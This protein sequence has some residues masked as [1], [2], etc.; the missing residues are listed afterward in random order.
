MRNGMAMKAASCDHPSH[1]AVGRNT[2]SDQTLVLSNLSIPHLTVRKIH[3]SDLSDSLSKGMADFNARPTH[4]VFLCA[5]YPIV[6]LFIA[7][8][9]M[10]GS[11]LPILFPLVGGF[12][13]VGPIVATGFYELSRRRENGLD[14]AW[15]NVFG[16]VRSPAMGAIVEFGLI[17]TIVFLA[18]LGTAEIIYKVTLGPA[19]PPLVAGFVSDVFTA[20]SGWVL[21]VAGNLAGL[22][23]ASVA[24]TIGIVTVPIL[25][26]RH[27]GLKTAVATSVRCMAAN[28][29][30]LMLWGS[31]VAS[32]L[33]IGMLTLFVGLAVVLPVLGHSTWHLYR[34][35]VE[36]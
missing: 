17:L 31:L 25:L 30:M 9:S 18:W 23:F 12:A 34:R 7:S 24:L 26:D 8:A 15:T 27:V 3:W 10:G 36:N 29:V 6:G 33:F 35:L 11:L 19:A 32:A 2:L 22:L 5:I 28:P 21:V 1:E 13:L 20:R 4:M 16:I 14:A